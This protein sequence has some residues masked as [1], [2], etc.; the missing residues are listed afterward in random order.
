MF[1]KAVPVLNVVS[2]QMAMTGLGGM[3]GL[4]APEL[5]PSASPLSVLSPQLRDTLNTQ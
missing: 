5:V 1:Q 2:A 4:G 3:P